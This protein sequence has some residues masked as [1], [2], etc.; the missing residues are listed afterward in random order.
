MTSLRNAGMLLGISLASALL[1]PPAAA[2]TGSAAFDR[3]VQDLRG[4]L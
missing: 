2:D 3:Y 1:S 4:R